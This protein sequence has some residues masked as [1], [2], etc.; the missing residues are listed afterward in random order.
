MRLQTGGENHF[1]GFAWVIRRLHNAHGS[2]P[3]PVSI[4]L[5]LVLVILSLQSKPPYSEQIIDKK[6]EE[7]VFRR[8]RALNRRAGAGA[9]PHQ[10]RRRHGGDHV[11]GGD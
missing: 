9:L 10:R 8:G 5:R 11:P 2:P 4:F 7:A 1:Y 6:D 3:L